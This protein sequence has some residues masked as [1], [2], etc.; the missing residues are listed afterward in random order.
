MKTLP[1]IWSKLRSRAFSQSVKRD[2]D[3]ELQFHLDTANSQKIEG[4]MSP[5]QATRASRCQFGN[6]QRI[7]EEC[8][9]IRGASFGETTLQDIR[10]GFRL[11]RKNPSF[12]IVAILT[13]AIGIGANTAIF[14]VINGVLLKP[15]PY[16]EP[17][18]LVTLWERD[19]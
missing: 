7:R 16:P 3:E 13:L 2:I 18:R 4:G 15:L 12:S 11:L 1:T 5:E 10:F 6:V 9:D 8:R 14:S 17:D 19:A